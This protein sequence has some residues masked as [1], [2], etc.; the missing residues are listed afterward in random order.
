MKSFHVI[1]YV[2]I[3]LCS[4]LSSFAQEPQNTARS[5]STTVDGFVSDNTA[6]DAFFSIEGG[7][8]GFHAILSA[9][10]GVGSY[11]SGSDGMASSFSGGHGVLAL[12]NDV[13]GVRSQQN[14]GRGFSSLHNTG[15]GIYS[16]NNDDDEGYFAGTVTVTGSLAKAAGSFK[17]D[18]PLDPENKFLYHSF[19]ESPDMMNVYNGNITTDASGFATITMPDYFEVLNRDFRYQ[20][21]VIGVFAQAII[22]EKLEDLKFVI[23]TDQPNVEVSWQI[24]GIRQDP[25]ANK[26]R[27][28]VE[29]DKEEKFIGQYIHPEAYDQPFEKGFDYI[30]LGK[31]TMAELMSLADE[32]RK[33]HQ[34]EVQANKVTE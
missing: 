11:L 23:Q 1:F 30:K 16:F 18:H 4:T 27:I 7:D 14:A 33:V 20:L 24:T 31:K 10:R 21:T 5:S 6:G 28:E 8:H 32:E 13:D 2:L 9:D 19:V 34:A 17:I 22:K 26:N 3:V 25:Y 15:D 29:V 12:S